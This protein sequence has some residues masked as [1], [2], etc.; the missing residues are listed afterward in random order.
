MNQ[1]KAKQP[2]KH[3]PRFKGD[4]LVYCDGCEYDSMTSIGQNSKDNL[5]PLNA[6]EL[7]AELCAVTGELETLKQSL[8]SNG[9][10]VEANLVQ[11]NEKLQAQVAMLRDAGRLA[12]NLDYFREHNALATTMQNALDSTASSDAWMK[13]HDAK[14][15]EEFAFKWLPNIKRHDYQ[16]SRQQTDHNYTVDECIKHALSMASELRSPESDVD[17]ATRLT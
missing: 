3:R 9:T 16:S 5:T 4:W 15:L 7:E 2:C 11:K 8:T 6:V 12:M 14:L 17:Q 10:I 13:E 1:C